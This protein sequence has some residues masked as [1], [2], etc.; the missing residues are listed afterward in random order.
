[1][2]NPEE[3]KN[4]EPEKI[5]SVHVE[6]LPMNQVYELLLDHSRKTLIEEM[7]SHRETEIRFWIICGVAAFA[8]FQ[9][10]KLKSGVE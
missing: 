5:G 6:H 4:P 2:D 9:W 1:M 10:Y 7:R 3:I 8:L